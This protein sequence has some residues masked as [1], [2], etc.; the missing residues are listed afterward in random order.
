MEYFVDYVGV[1]N[2]IRQARKNRKWTQAQ[3]AEAVGCSTANITN[4]E[5]AKTK[6]SLNMILRIAEV[7]D[8]SVDALAGTGKTA[9]QS[10]SSATELGLREI[11]E[12]LS[13]EDAR[14]CQE[15]CME[16]C[17]AFSR[18]LKQV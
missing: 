7:L 14:L 6:L 16:F 3:L 18:H 17:T 12:G 2:R 13:P 5:R 11:W 10:P 4:V 9:G 8:V 15:A 1:G